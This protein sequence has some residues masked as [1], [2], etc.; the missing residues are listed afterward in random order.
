MSI[1]IDKSTRLLVQGITGR[2]GLFH[3]QQMVEYGTRLVAGVRPGSPGEAA[4]S[5]AVTT[6]TSLTGSTAASDPAA[7]TN[8]AKAMRMGLL[9][10]GDAPYPFLT[11]R[12]KARM[13]PRSLL[14][15]KDIIKNNID[16]HGA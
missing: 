15:R 3:S 7:M 4:G 10:I 6:R 13:V 8:T 1:L 9:F 14:L 2:E 5:R 12:L 16:I 11:P